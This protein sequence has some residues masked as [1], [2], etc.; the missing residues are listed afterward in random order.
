MHGVL[1][2]AADKSRPYLNRT[3]MSRTR[4]ELLA[5]TG[6]RNAPASPCEGLG[7]IAAVPGACVFIGKPCDVAGATKLSALSS[8]LKERL[9]LTIAFFRAGTPSTQRTLGLL[10]QAGVTDAESV[11]S[12]RTAALAGR[13]GGR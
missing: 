5:R 2:A 8:A 9:G 3:V 4:E 10:K 1:H 7:K 6:L 11:T 12:R 13:D